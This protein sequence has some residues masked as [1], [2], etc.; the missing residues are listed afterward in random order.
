MSDLFASP[1][2]TILRAQHHINDLTG[3]INEFVT[4]QPWSHRAESNAADPTQEVHKIVFERR[5]PADL[6]N[7]V[8][9][10]ANN[11]RAVLDQSGYASAVASGKIDP[12]NTQFPFGDDPA[13]LDQVIRRGRC[14]DLPSEILGLFRSFRP[15]RGGNDILWALNKLCNAKK[16]C[17]LV[18]FNLGRA[19]IGAMEVAKLAPVFRPD[20]MVDVTWNVK[21]H[22]FT[23][24]MSVKNPDWNADK[25]E[26]TLAKI[27]REIGRN[28]KANVDLNVA[29]DGVDTQQGKPAVGLLNDMMRVI[30]GILAATET[31][32]R[33][34]GFIK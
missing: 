27:P 1:R 24:G 5:L 7:I 10:A 4:N 22:G 14:K 16:H 30:D 28:Y 34:L 17:A 31:E 20:G 8:F 21:T 25:Y 13:G 15:Y 26:I 9:D 19:N 3:K 6:P 18:P 32:C 23:G 11:L 12:K 2:L 33:R 29:I